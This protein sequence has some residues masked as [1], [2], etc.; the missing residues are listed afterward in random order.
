MPRQRFLLAAL[1]LLTLWR[2]ALLPTLE[3]APDEALAVF[4]AK[5]GPWGAFLGH[6]PLVPLLAR[7]GMLLG[8]ASEAGVRLLAPLLALAASLLVWRLARELY[9]EHIA[10]WA[11]VILNV[12]PAFNL[13]A[14][15]L[16]PALL[17]CVLLPA[18]VLLM[19]RALRDEDPKQ[20]PWKAAAACVVGVALAQPPALAVMA[21]VA[22][23]LALPMQ[24]RQQL[25]GTGFRWIA[26]GWAVV[27][28]LWLISQAVDGWPAF[29]AWRWL[30]EWRLVPSLMRWIVLASPMLLILLVMSV[31]AGL[32]GGMLQTQR[33]L[34][35]ALLLPLAGIEFFY[36][37]HESWPGTGGAVWMLFGAVLLAHRGT[38]ARAAVIEQKISLRTV[39]LVLAALQSAFLLQ[40]DLPRTLGLRWPF[41]TSSGAT[42]DYTRVILADP[43]RAVRGWRESARVVSSVL[44]QAGGEWSVLADDRVLAAELDFY[45]GRAEPVQ[46]ADVDWRTMAGRS[47][48]FVTEDRAACRP[49]I[50]VRRQFQSIELLTVAR[51]MHAG[52]EVRWLK[53]F[54]CHGCRSPDS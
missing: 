13:A 7:L 45:L 42:T 22:L 47:V 1:G 33:G 3:L 6:G 5:H 21:A 53:I 20:R 35:L 11:V 15:T 51:V 52:N 50:W 17:V 23:A 43:A 8:G 14:V 34:P 41:S 44:Q 38:V 26:G 4:Q 19:R 29:M 31:R 9:D 46:S 39:A 27:G 30:P 12:L 10:G 40:T 2:W 49:P 54:A 36:G 28:L 32:A 18:A 37:P 16:T 48:L 24:A 25:R